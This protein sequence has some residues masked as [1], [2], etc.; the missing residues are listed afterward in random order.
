V[1]VKEADSFIR[2][3]TASQAGK[4]LFRLTVIRTCRATIGTPAC[5]KRTLGTPPLGSRGLSQACTAF[6]ASQNGL[7]R[8]VS[9]ANKRAG[10]ESL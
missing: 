1:K 6:F 4:T 7:L 8:I 2:S 10:S 9:Y 3:E 5:T